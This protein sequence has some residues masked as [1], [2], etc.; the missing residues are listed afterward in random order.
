MLANDAGW[1]AVLDRVLKHLLAPV[2]CLVAEQDVCSIDLDLAAAFGLSR[3]GA[4]LVRPNG[5]VAWR[6]RRD[7]VNQ[8][9]ALN[10]ALRLALGNGS[11]PVSR[12]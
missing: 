8:A 2:R 11:G 5:V 10:D 4:S 12:L 6:S 1:R 3:S 9:L 7:Q